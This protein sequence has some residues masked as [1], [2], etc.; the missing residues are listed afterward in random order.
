MEATVSLATVVRV[1]EPVEIVV[2]MVLLLMLL[3]VGM[4]VKVLLVVASKVLV[5]ILAV[6]V[7]WPAKVIVFMEKVLKAKMLITLVLTFSKSPC[8]PVT[9]RWKAEALENVLI[10]V[11]ISKQVIKVE[12][13]ATAT[14][15]EVKGVC[16]MSLLVVSLMMLVV[17]L[18]MVLMMM[19]E[20]LVKPTEEVIKVEIGLKILSTITLHPFFTKHVILLSLFGVRQSFIC[21]CNFYKLFLCILVFILVRVVLYCQLSESFFNF[22]L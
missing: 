13:E 16:A 18:M 6:L 17:S 22:L 10:H 1:V 11:C 12:V 3:E 4:V 19:P 7:M 21:F 20:V 8:F 9:W 5:T 15:I 14:S 2:M